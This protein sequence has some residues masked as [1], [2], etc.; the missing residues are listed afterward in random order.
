MP[1]TAAGSELGSVAPGSVTGILPA[2]TAGTVAAPSMPASQADAQP[3]AAITNAQAAAEHART[4]PRSRLWQMVDSARRML[5]IGRRRRLWHEMEEAGAVEGQGQAEAA[6]AGFGASSPLSLSSTLAG[7]ATDWPVLSLPG[8]TAVAGT[9][10][11]AREA[12]AT[13]GMGWFEATRRRPGQM[14]LLRNLLGCHFSPMLARTLV[15]L[16]PSD[17]ADAQAD[18]WLR[19]M[20]MRALAGVNQ[21]VGLTLGEERTLFDAGGVF[22]LIGPT[23]VGKTTSIAKIAAHHV[24]RHG[25]RSLA[26]ITADVYRIGAQEQL[27]A[28]GRML[29][30]PVQVAQDREVLQRLLKEHEGCRLVLIDTAG[31]GQR[32]DRVGQLT[33]ALEV[34]QV[35]RVLVMNAAAQPGSLE[36]VLGAFGARDTAGVLLSKVDEAVGLGACLDALVRHRLP[37]LGYADGQRVPEDYHAVNFGRLVEMALDRQAVARF[38]A[39]SM[40]DNELRNLFEGSHV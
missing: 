1:G 14:R 15:E 33:S 37:L 24:L 19:Q 27:R 29:G 5:G 36:E 34:S 6:L 28:F 3:Q 40:T 9:A 20:L 32:D 22:A 10:E 2:T 16:L 21:G 18:E 26:L 39:L 23:G 8:D 17:Y 4:Q 38:P 31:I 11:D 25:P 7:P 30:V 35:R 13:S 12:W